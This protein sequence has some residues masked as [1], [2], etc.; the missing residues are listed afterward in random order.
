MKLIKTQV[1]CKGCQR[2]HTIECNY[3]GLFSKVLA[4]WKC[5]RCGSQLLAEIKKPWF[6]PK[7][8]IKVTMVQHS[9]TL[10]NML[11]RRKMQCQK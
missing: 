9:K 3:P 8:L 6:Q 2:N 4:P 7:I 1:Q 5:A 11:N 10:L